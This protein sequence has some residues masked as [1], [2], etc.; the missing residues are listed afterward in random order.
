MKVS[1]I[2]KLLEFRDI[3]KKQANQIAELAKKGKEPSTIIAISS[4]KRPEKRTE[5]KVVKQ[6][7]QIAAIHIEK[8]TDNRSIDEKIKAVKA[9]KEELTSIDKEYTAKFN[10]VKKRLQR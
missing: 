4:K 2:V 10:K 5:Q 9:L 8:K 6:I 3:G 7:K 1:E